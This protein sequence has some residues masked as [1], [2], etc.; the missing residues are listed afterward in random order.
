MTNVSGTPTT[1]FSFTD[2]GTFTAVGD[3]VAYS[4][5]RIKTNIKTIENALEKVI[6]MRGVTYNR[7]DTE[8]KNEKIGVIAQEIQKVIPQV[9]TEDSTGTLGVAYGNITAILIE[10]IKELEQKIKELEQKIEDLKK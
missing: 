7:I 2:G 5:D 9:I 4:D 10:A 8:D 3:V 6:S 1:R